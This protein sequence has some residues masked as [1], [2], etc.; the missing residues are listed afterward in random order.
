MRALSEFLF[1]GLVL[2]IL[3]KTTMEEFFMK[4]KVF[5]FFLKFFLLIPEQPMCHYLQIDPTL[6]D[7][8]KTGA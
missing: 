4:T 3:E 5:C 8:P 2:E 7:R 6:R 1:H